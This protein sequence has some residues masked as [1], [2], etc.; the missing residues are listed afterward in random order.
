MAALRDAAIGGLV[1]VGLICAGGLARRPPGKRPLGVEH[2]AR[3]IERVTRAYRAAAIDQLLLVLGYEAK[4]ILQQIPLQG[5]KIVINA[6]YRRGVC[7]SLETGLRFLPKTCA[8]I[9]IGL[10][11]MPLIEPETINQLVHTFHKTRKGIVYPTYGKQVGLPI[12]FDI[13]YREELG[14]LRGDGGPVQFVEQFHK[15]TKAVKVNTPAVVRDIVSL[16]EF[17]E[18][19]GAAEEIGERQ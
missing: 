14:R 15:D 7:T 3:V 11:D 12:V 2:I 16:D 1:V 18:L 17:E 19:V 10:G 4:R 13:K 6:Q 5:M 8:A 9:V